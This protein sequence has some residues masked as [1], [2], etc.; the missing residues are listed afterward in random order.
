MEVMTLSA[1]FRSIVGVAAAGLLVMSGLWLTRERSRIYGEKEERARNLVEVPYSILMKYHAQETEG[2]ITRPEAQQRALDVI[3]TMRYENDNYFW[4]NDMH[5]TMV[6]HP[7]SSELDGKDLSDY[8]DPKGTALFVEFVKVVRAQGSGFVSYLWPRPGRDHKPVP[9]LSFVKGFQPWGWVIGTGIYTDDV[10]AVWRESA[11]FA[12]A[13]ALACLAALLVISTGISRSVFR[14]LSTLIEVAQRIAKGDLREKVQ[15]VGRDEVAA[16]L[17]A[18]NEMAESLSR[19]IR[20]VRGSASGLASAAAQASATSQSVSNGTSEQAASVEET[21]S[22]LEEMS[23]SITQ[24]AENSRQTEQMALKGVQDAEQCKAAVAETV[25]VMNAIAQKITIIEEI[26]FQTNLLALNAAIEAA[27]AGDQGKGFAVV[28]TE[29]RKLAERSQAAAKEIGALSTSSVQ[30][31]E[32]SGTLLEALVPAIRKTAELVQEVTAASGEQSSGV[33][34]INSAMGQVDQVA[35]RNASASEELASTAEEM[36]S[37]AESLQQLV[38]FFNIDSS[39]ETHRVPPRAV[40]AT[41]AAPRLVV[42]QVAA[43][44]GKSNG[45]TQ[46][47]PGQPDQHFRQF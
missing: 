46:G 24:N 45:P 47:T 42:T 21:T 28:A 43:A 19:V 9:K 16:L 40:F 38:A 37:Q 7:V 22:S 1:K 12:G 3:G 10:D 27:H 41:P 31:A 35:Q 15:V 8:R 6:M 36:A 5:P 39:A 4:I 25:G 34:Q 13:A 14:R 23:A 11:S 33:A 32:R 2:K 29:V 30:V 17:S 20:D 18:M 44:P 26:A